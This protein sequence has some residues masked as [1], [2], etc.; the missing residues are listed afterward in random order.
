MGR[1]LEQQRLSVPWGTEANSRPRE[2]PVETLRGLAIL[3]MVAGHVIGWTGGLGMRV[4]ADSGYRYFVDSL[5]FLRM[6]LFT[7]ISGFVYAMRPVGPGSVP[8]FLQ[9]KARRLLVPLLTLS[10]LQFVAKAVVPSVNSPVE[11]GQM[12]RIYLF[13]FDHFWFLQALALIFVVVALL[14]GSEQMRSFRGWALVAALALAAYFFM[15]RF[16][17]LFAFPDALYLLPYFL[18]G[19]GMRRFAPVFARPAL[20]PIAL[21]CFSIA[22]AA[23]QLGLLG[24]FE[25]RFDKTSLGGLV[26]GLAG[27]FLLF[28]ARLAS[29]W[30]AWLGSYAYSIY[31]MHIF[32]MSG[33]RIVLTRLGI[34]HHAVIFLAGLATGVLLPIVAD[35]VF[36][37]NRWTRLL[38]LG[39]GSAAAPRNHGRPRSDDGTS[40]LRRA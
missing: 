24:V 27:C 12:W 18:L 26:I 25:H 9:G 8:S 36:R 22:F 28:R 19:V 2:L 37:K 3:L 4:A 38:F 32:P 31:L 6:P 14:D 17:T 30:L 13:P 21:F 15:P 11:F 29:T 20:T 23:H 7:V 16:T 5:M 1:T 35:R 39:L 34:D 10:S 40:L 33:S